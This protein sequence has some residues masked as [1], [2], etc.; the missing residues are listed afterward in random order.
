MSVYSH[1]IS[2]WERAERDAC[3]SPQRGARRSSN[4]ADAGSEPEF[5]WDP[6]CRSSQVYLALLRRALFQMGISISQCMLRVRSNS[7][8]SQPPA[9]FTIRKFLH[10][11]FCYGFHILSNVLGLVQ[12]PN[13]PIFFDY[14]ALR[15]DIRETLLKSL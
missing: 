6:S 5:R 2:S 11:M 10:N 8:P 15:L 14:S 7:Q 9:Q 13:V 1:T 4:K 12:K 3:L